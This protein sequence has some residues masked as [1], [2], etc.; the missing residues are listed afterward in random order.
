MSMPSSA[1]PT[2]EIS[3]ADVLG[4]IEK[5]APIIAKA[6]AQANSSRRLPPELLDALHEQ[7]LFRLL[8]PKPYGGLEVAPPTF[9][10]AMEAVAKHDASTAWCLCQ[11]N[12]CAMTAAYLEPEIAQEIWGRDPRAVLA[13]GP[14]KVEARVD[15]DGY[16]ISGT[17][18][19]ASGSRHAT[20]LGSHC[21]V[22]DADGSTRRDEDGNIVIR[23]MLFPADK[24]TM[25]DV[26]DVIGLRGTGSDSFSVTDMFVPHDHSTERES[27][28]EQ[29]YHAPLYHLLAMNLY[30]S[31]FSGTALGIAGGMVEAFMELAGEKTPRLARSRLRDGGRPARRCSARRRGHPV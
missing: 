14:G 21:F 18:A 8:L 24:A 6:S 29:R 9:F 22:V 10:Q 15:G 5:I 13:W 25:I 28:A 3:E 17:C 4:R 20:W 2:E 1:S 19:F 11:G 23:T 31:G 26:W 16:R 27:V 30:A 7:K 12:G